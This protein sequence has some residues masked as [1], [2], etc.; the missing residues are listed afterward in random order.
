M[1]PVNVGL[2]QRGGGKAALHGALC[3]THMGVDMYIE[4]IKMRS[5]RMIYFQNYHNNDSWIYRLKCSR[6]ALKSSSL[7]RNV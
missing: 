3:I 1:H 6:N 5:T 7:S 2:F 4:N